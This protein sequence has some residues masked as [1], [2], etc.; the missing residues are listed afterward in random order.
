VGRRQRIPSIQIHIS[1]NKT[2]PATPH[3]L[4]QEQKPVR[5][6]PP[7]SSRPRKLMHRTSLCK[8]LLPPSDAVRALARAP[9]PPC[10]H[11]DSYARPAV[12]QG[13][14][15]PAGR[16]RH[17]TQADRSR[18]SFLNPR[19]QKDL[20]KRCTDW[21]QPTPRGQL[22]TSLCNRNSRPALHRAHGFRERA[23]VSQQNSPRPS[24]LSEV[25][26]PSPTRR[27]RSPYLLTSRPIRARPPS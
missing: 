21:L 23:T 26:A 19:T 6:S 27:P 24:S 15:R 2:R 8:G 20:A 16:G 17:C 11:D 3:S 14:S 25:F 1:K 18:W 10:Q 22:T 9:H 5:S 7:L 4:L 12:R 13:R